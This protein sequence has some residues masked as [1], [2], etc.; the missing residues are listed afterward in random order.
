MMKFDHLAIP[1]TDLDRSREWYIAALGLK[2]EFAI[3]ERRAVALQDSAG[4]TIFLNESATSVQPNGTAFWFQV[5]DVEA[6][7]AALS[8]RGV[9]FQHGPRKSFWGYGVELADPDGYLVRLWDETS[10]REK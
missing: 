1:V 2:V 4:F 8:A 3:P 10:M 7:F 5:E 6:S 9:A